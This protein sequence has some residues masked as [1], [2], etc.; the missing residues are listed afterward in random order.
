MLLIADLPEWG[1]W[2][3]PIIK[4]VSEESGSSIWT[5]YLEA[6]VHEANGDVSAMT[7]TVERLNENHPRFGPAY[8]WNLQLTKAQHPLTPFDPD[9]VTVRNRRL[10]YL[11]EELIDDPVEVALA[12]AGA[13]RRILDTGSAMRTLRAVLR[14]AGDSKTEVRLM[15]GWLAVEEENWAAAAEHYFAA[16]LGDPGIYTIRVINSLLGILDGSAKQGADQEGTLSKKRAAEM[17]AALGER[18]PLD[19]MVT[20][21]RLQLSDLDRGAWGDWA[22]NALDALYRNSGRQPLEAIRPG[23]TRPWVDLLMDIRI[24]LARSIVER[25]LEHEPGN[26]VLWR[27]RAEIASALNDDAAAAEIYRALIVI[28][29]SALST[30]YELAEIMIAQGRSM[31]DVTEILEEAGQ[32]EGGGGARSV[33][34][35]ALAET[36]TR[37]PKLGQIIRRLKEPWKA[38]DRAASGVDPTLLGELYVEALLALNRP[39]DQQE[40]S[41]VLAD[42]AKKAPDVPYRSVTVTAMQGLH[43][44]SLQEA[45]TR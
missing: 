3:L 13:F 34:L 7:A 40:V 35:S 43:T 6:L 9:V 28:D 36:R 15:M 12:K 11:T 16:A 41:R 27:L 39:E 38:R 14:D 10:A 23:S 18:Y 42:L 1:A 31:T 8:D 26:L 2:L 5:G 44:R 22:K 32:K 33:Y 25:D 30:G 45:G 17:L 37:N 20:L 24:D 29:R 21:R 19:P 4:K